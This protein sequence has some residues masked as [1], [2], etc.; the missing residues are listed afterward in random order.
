MN[1]KFCPYDKLEFYIL[2]LAGRCTHPVMTVAV[3]RIMHMLCPLLD[4]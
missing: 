1:F 4:T 3:F 2:D